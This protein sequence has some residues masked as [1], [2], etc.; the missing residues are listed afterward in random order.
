MQKEKK[1]RGQ[2][3]DICPPE[4]ELEPDIEI[5]Q[6]IDIELEEE[7]EK[8]KSCATGAEIS[9]NVESVFSYY[10]TNIT[11]L[12]DEQRKELQKYSEKMQSELIINAIKEAVD[13]NA[14]SYKYVL[15]ILQ[16][17]EKSNIFTLNTF[18]KR[19]AEHEK[20]KQNKNNRSN[21]LVPFKTYEQRNYK[22]GELNSLYMNRK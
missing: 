2:K 1:K 16:N 15:A 8:E 5:E 18:L 7:K 3:A 20:Q 13:Y 6:E 4:I 22:D 9:Q 10:E 19:Q 11:K 21:K 14:K 17:C 12:T